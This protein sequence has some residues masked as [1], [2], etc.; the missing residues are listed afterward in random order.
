MDYSIISI[1]SEND[2]SC[3]LERFNK[4][5]SSGFICCSCSETNV[6]KLVLG[7]YNNES[8]ES[9]ELLSN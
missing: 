7:S 9:V 1:A 4:S 8:E 5:T 2:V 6:S 3:V